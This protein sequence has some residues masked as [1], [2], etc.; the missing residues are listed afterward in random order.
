MLEAA[1]A[2][3]QKAERFQQVRAELT[4]ALRSGQGLPAATETVQDAAQKLGLPLAMTD[5]LA[6]LGMSHRSDGAG[7]QWS[8]SL[9]RQ[10][11]ESAER[12]GDGMRAASLWLMISINAR[13]ASPSSAVARSAWT[14]AVNHRIQYRLRA[15]SLP[16][17]TRF[18]L[19]AERY[20]P[21]DTQWPAGI[22]QVLLPTARAVGCEFSSNSPPEL[23]IWCAVGR[24][25]ELAGDAQLALISYKRAE[26]FALGSSVLMAADR[27]KWMPFVAWAAWARRGTIGRSLGKSRARGGKRRQ[28]GRRCCEASSRS[29]STGC[30]VP[31]QGT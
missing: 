25:Q 23:V 22:F 16:I 26:A 6:L 5:T 17:N 27:T 10:A 30:A 2:H 28:R 18:W 3:P 31:Q 29:V 19:E 13:Q 12:H 11:A 8:E 4:D 1:R 9:L 20:R 14:N 7:G 15:A 24:E 21:A